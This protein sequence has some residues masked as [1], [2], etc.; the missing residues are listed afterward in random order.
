[1]KTQSLVTKSGKR[2]FRPVLT[3][4]EFQ[5]SDNMGFC[6]SCGETADGVE[7]DARRYECDLCGED[8]IYGLEE[9]LIMGALKIEGGDE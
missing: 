6:I 8:R 1:M 7:P 2:V 4:Q 9:L 5:E 3:A